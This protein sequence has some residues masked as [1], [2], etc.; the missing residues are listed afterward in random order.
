MSSWGGVT[1]TKTVEG[2]EGNPS[3]T[4]TTYVRTHTKKHISK[5]EIQALRCNGETRGR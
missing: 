1:S 5:L 3:H 4:Y 2:K